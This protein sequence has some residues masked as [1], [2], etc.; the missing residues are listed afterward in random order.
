M[1]KISASVDWKEDGVKIL[2]HIVVSRQDFEQRKYD[3]GAI[4]MDIEE[5]CFEVKAWGERVKRE[6]IGGLMDELEKEAF[7]KTAYEVRDF[8]VELYNKHDQIGWALKLM[9]ILREV[10]MEGTLLSE[11]FK[12]DIDALENEKRKLESIRAEVTAAE[13]KTKSRSAHVKISQGSKIRTMLF[14][15]FG[16]ALFIYVVAYGIV[17]KGA[18]LEQVKYNEPIENMPENGAVKYFTD[19]K[20]EAPF[21]IKTPAGDGSCYILLKDSKDNKTVVSVF[22][23]PNSEKEIKVPLGNSIRGHTVELDS[24]LDGNLPTSEVDKEAFSN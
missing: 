7:E 9:K 10:I 23:Y 3:D 15:F 21:S 16:V 13:E 4:F 14:F 22:L 6:T 8:A 19:N 2:K 12:K 5:L 20:N 24:Q 11:K 18:S 17:T 1:E